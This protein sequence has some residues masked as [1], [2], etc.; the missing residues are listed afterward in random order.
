MSEEFKVFEA[1]MIERWDNH[2]KRADSNSKRTDDSLKLIF[3]KIEEGVKRKDGC[4]KESRT[5][6]NRAVAWAIAIP[7]TLAVI[8]GLVLFLNK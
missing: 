3:K 7:S 1:K 2:D 8:V 5:Y 4:M 6:T